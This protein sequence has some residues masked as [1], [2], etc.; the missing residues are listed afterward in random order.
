MF[1]DFE[2]KPFGKKVKSFT[3]QYPDFPKM[4]DIIKIYCDCWE[5]LKFNKETV[6]I[7][8]SGFHHHFYRFDYKITADREKIPMLQWLKD[9][10]DYLGYSPEQKA[11]S[12]A[13]YEQS[14]QYKDV[15]FDGDYTYKGKR[16]A[17]M[18]LSGYSAL[19][20]SEFT[21]H[22]RL[23]SMD[24]YIAE[25]EAMPESIKK[26]MTK[27]S[28]R[29]CNFQGAMPGHCKFRVHWTFN[30]QPHIGCAHLCFYFYDYDVSNIP[31]YWRL[32]ELEYGLKKVLKGRSK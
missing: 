16:I 30:R 17:R 6:K 12:V 18:C 8:P 15:K 23:K 9:E 29:N 20:N 1:S 11:F 25:M 2:G 27:D 22:L 31:N 5:A 14:L 10:T 4:I 26:Y 24:K 19:G 21:V 3:A 13:F 32:L 7:Q 28:C